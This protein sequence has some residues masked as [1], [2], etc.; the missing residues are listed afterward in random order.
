MLRG[1]KFTA[2]QI[3]GKLHEDVGRKLTSEDVWE[4]LGDRFVRHGVPDHIRSDNGS[5]FSI[6]SFNGKLQDELLA[7]ELFDT[8]LEATVLI[9]R[10][11]KA[12]NPVRPHISLGNRPPAP[13][14]RR[15][16]PLARRRRSER[17]GAIPWHGY[18][19][20]RN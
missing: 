18:T 13:E 19:D 9:D 15:P 20:H 2:E 6:E 7:W 8:L 10:C 1:K 11:R 3:I 5:E 14:S 16:C 12:S 17:T 4:R